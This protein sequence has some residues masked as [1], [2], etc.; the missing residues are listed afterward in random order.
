M[1]NKDV[2]Q[3]NT[4][5]L[6]G[7]SKKA[8]YSVDDNGIYTITPSSGWEAEDV[9]L[10]DVIGDYEEKAE[11]ARLKVSKN[12]TSPIEYFM[13]KRYMDL[14]GLSQAMGISTLRIKRHFK[15]DVFKKLKN[16]I[17]QE[18]AHLFRIDIDTLKNF[19]REE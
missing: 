3:D 18:Y 10:L 16:N 7:I 12:E 11:E 6:K 4:N 8:I 5:T 2:P 9:V 17:V 19:T 1:K 15:P 13:Y 14:P